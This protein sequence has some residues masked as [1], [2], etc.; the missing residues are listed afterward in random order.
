[1]GRQKDDRRSGQGRAL[2]SQAPAQRQ[3][4]LSGQHDV[5]QNEIGTNLRRLVEK[6]GAAGKMRDLKPAA[7]QSLDDQFGNFTFV[8]NQDDSRHAAFSRATARLRHRAKLTAPM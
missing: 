7:L 1:M 8:F 2:G 4:V 6:K 3:A 5:K